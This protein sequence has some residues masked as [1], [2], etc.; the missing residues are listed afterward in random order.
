[1]SSKSTGALGYEASNAGRLIVL[2][3]AFGARA[4]GNRFGCGISRCNFLA[5]LLLASLDCIQAFAQPGFFR[6]MPVL[7]RI[8]IC[9]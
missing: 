7:I 3:I 5:R 1:M 9:G 8:T 6:P 4:R 2:R